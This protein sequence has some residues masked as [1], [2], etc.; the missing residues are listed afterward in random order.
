MNLI[1]LKEKTALF[2]RAVFLRKSVVIA[3]VLFLVHS[4]PLI[5]QNENARFTNLSVEHGLSNT[6]VYAIQQTDDG[7]IWI[8]TQNGLNRYDGY[9]F[10]V[11][12]FVPGDTTA[13]SNNWVKALCTDKNQNLWVGTSNGLNRFNRETETFSTYT[14][15]SPSNALAD[16]NIWCLFTDRK[17][18]VWVGTNN[19]LCRYDE[20]KDGFVTYRISQPHNNA[21]NT[22]AEDPEGHIWVGTWGSGIFRLDQSNGQ[23]TDF[24]TLTS[25]S[26]M[27]GQYV[28]V[29]KIDQQG[30]YWM[31]TQGNGLHRYEPAGRQYKIFRHEAQNQNSISDNAI[32]SLLED[33][34]GQIWAGTYDG[35]IS[36]YNE[37]Q[38]NF[39]R[40]QSDFLI[41]KSLGGR[42]ITSLFEDK[43]GIIWAGHD[44]G[45]S[46]MNPKGQKFQLFENNPFNANSIPP[47]NINVIYEDR[48]GLLWFGTWGDGISSYDRKNRQFRHYRSNP[49]QANALSSDQIW[50]IAEDAAGELWIATSQGLDK[51]N[52]NNGTFEHRNDL[53]ATESGSTPAYFALSALMVDKKGRMWVGAWGNGLYVHDPTQKKTIHLSNQ[54]NQPNS[55]SNNQIRHI[56]VDSQENA[57]ICTAEGGL[58][59]L[60]FDSQGRPLFKLYTYNSKSPHS[61]GSNSPMLVYED[62]K[63]R[64][65]VGT[66]GSGLSQ[67][68][69][70]KEQFKRIRT[71]GEAVPF[72]SVYG[73]LED[74]RGTLWLSTNNGIINY[75][76]DSFLIQ[77]YDISDGLQS[78]TFLAGSCK[79][80]AGDMLFG[81]HN[82]FN[83]F[84]PERTQESSAFLPRVLITELRL[85]NEPIGVGQIHEKIGHTRPL[86]EKPLHLLDEIGLSY[87]D[88]V[89]SFGFTALDFTAPQKNRYAYKLV[90]FEKDWNYTD[91]SQRVATYTNLKPGE[92]IFKVKGSNSDG[93]WNEQAAEIRVVVAPPFWQTWWAYLIYVLLIIGALWL[94][95]QYTIR[96]ERLK[97]ELEMKRLESEKL[98]E[99]DQMKSRFFTNISHEFRTPLTLILGPLEKKLA[100][101]KAD[102]EEE[103]DFRMMYRNANRLLQLINQLMDISKLEAGNVKLELARGDVLYFLRTIVFSFSS[104]AESKGVELVYSADTSSHVAYFDK[105]KLEKIIANLLSNAFKFTPEGGKVMVSVK[106]NRMTSE[107]AERG[108]GSLAADHLEITVEDT[109]VGIPENQVTRIFDRFYQVDGSQ[110]PE[111]GGTGIGLALT[112]ELVTLYRGTIAVTSEVGKGTRFVL[113]IPMNLE[114]ISS[115]EGILIREQTTETS[116][117]TEKTHSPGVEKIPSESEA[118]KQEPA[119]QTD[120]SGSLPVLLIVE[121]NDEIR[122]YIA[123]CFKATYQILDARNGQEG[124]K[125]AIEAVP[126][127]IISDLMMPKMD[128]VEMCR[129]LKTDERTSHIPVVLLTARA[130]VESRLDG[131]E[132]G[133]DDY[134][135]KPFHPQELQVRARNLIESR[136]KLRERYGRGLKVEP[137]EI[138]ITSAD[139]LFLQ[140]AIEV[141]EKYLSDSDFSVEMLEN[142]MSL[143][144]MQLYRKLKALTDQSP[145]EFIR[146]LRLK[147]AAALISSKAGTISEVVYTVGF[148]NLSYFA[149][150]FREMYGVNPSEYTGQ[151]ADAKV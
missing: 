64:L 61:L 104:L 53:L 86:L 107:T 108:N 145:N 11:F 123:A 146:T 82:G 113:Q 32:L 2:L 14:T 13:L 70:Q 137:R 150:C 100:A 8:A 72:N 15:R 120:A 93:I 89:L 42:W 125:K 131:L 80:R 58:N 143:S 78:N 23:F 114:R 151:E 116:N 96:R 87:K 66:E 74:D 44:N 45:I 117:G 110:S 6:S 63:K 84:T 55:L 90:N 34:K 12:S 83:L 20:K 75:D 9:H 88:Y 76:P 67:F 133:A 71:V 129:R 35:G 142:E 28:K 134:L 41:P 118:E 39:T 7:F 26:G 121:D 148:N 103:G 119:E 47:S 50:G 51:L 68:D 91:A 56:F 95:R 139:E 106:M 138:A 92:Y 98:L 54:P 18:N 30:R 130:S 4:I 79:T 60:S 31:G 65:W 81:G 17:G 22:I 57:W 97:N 101:L 85:F 59:R 124:L 147:R 105:D 73:I 52:R 46:K 136:R 132:T 94:L 27:E 135:T 149:K 21:I 140:K 40:Y 29:L 141:V 25:L 36:L 144:K 128:G 62:R 5:A 19:G 126:D 109:G 10:R 16:N 3:L 102:Q 69:R 24:K 111:R 127:L 99:V 77:G 115:A 122:Q 37:S 1:F 33:R 49:N 43:S 48:D 112:R 38:Q